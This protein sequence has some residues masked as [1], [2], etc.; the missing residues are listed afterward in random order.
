MYYSTILRGNLFSFSK[1][2][3]LST[4]RNQSQ[5]Q[6]H[7]LVSSFRSTYALA[8]INSNNV[9]LGP[10]HP[11][12]L[13]RT[14]H[15][16]FSNTF[17]NKDSSKINQETSS[18]SNDIQKI[19]KGFGKFAK[20]KESTTS[21]HKEHQI[22]DDASGDKN[23][24]NALKNENEPTKDDHENKSSTENESKQTGK[25]DSEQE[26]SNEKSNKNLKRRILQ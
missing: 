19:P 5:R 2:T 25:E 3:S 21:S 8:T 11:S 23:A 12:Q 15:A 9:P 18:S 22:T 4:L 16:G 1:P 10:C 6:L 7:L 14:S 13:N 24:S 26:P 20:N 17:F